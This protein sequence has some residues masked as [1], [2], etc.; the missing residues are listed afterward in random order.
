MTLCGP[1]GI[2]GNLFESE[3]FWSDFWGCSSV[4]QSPVPVNYR[5]HKWPTGILTVGP[6]GWS[7]PPKAY[8]YLTMDD[9]ESRKDWYNLVWRATKTWPE[10]TDWTGTASLYPEKVS[11]VNCPGA[12][13]LMQCSLASCTI[14]QMDPPLAEATSL[15]VSFCTIIFGC[16]SSLCWKHYHVWCKTGSSKCNGSNMN[17]TVFIPVGPLSWESTRV[18]TMNYYHSSQTHRRVFSICRLPSGG[19]HN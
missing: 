19:P 13:G 2:K 17:G 10:L 7:L 9:W 14:R 8:H 3:S 4:Q 16:V 1:E 6:R 12:E 5:E 18:T 15:G 11:I